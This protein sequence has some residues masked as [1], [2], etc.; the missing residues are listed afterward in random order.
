M[1]NGHTGLLTHERDAKLFRKW[2]DEMC[3]LQGIKV[4]YRRVDDELYDKYS[5]YGEIKEET[6]K[7]IE[8]WVMFEEYPKQKTMRK[9]GWNTEALDS[10]PIMHVPYDLP[11]LQR[12]CVFVIQSGVDSSEVR[13][14]KVL[15]LEN[16]AI[17]PYA[18]A[19]KLGPILKSD[20]DR[21]KLDHTNNNFSVFKDIESDLDGEETE[22]D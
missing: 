22:D 10:C 13:L 2:F 15:E 17:Y 18:M 11:D 3:H 19:C 14:F 6:G 8:V 5:D 20:F 21:S 9:L 7:P 1:D 12:G 16:D 4:I